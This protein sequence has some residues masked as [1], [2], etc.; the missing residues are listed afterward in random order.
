[1][2][3][4]AV[5]L[6]NTINPSCFISFGTVPSPSAKTL[7]E[8]QSIA[9]IVALVAAVGLVAVLVGCLG[10][11][12]P[13]TSAVIAPP[14]LSVATVTLSTAKK[15]KKANMANTASP[16]RD[17]GLVPQQQ[18]QQQ[19][20]ASLLWDARYEYHDS[21][22]QRFSMVPNTTNDDDEEAEEDLRRRYQ[23]HST[24]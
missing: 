12:K 4:H 18:Q 10:R 7:T 16:Y 20:L 24:M 1:M 19:Q 6:N 22:H 14:L 21:H 9:F 5:A 11:F 17:Q 2:L 3:S 13:T 8:Q 23:R 15:F